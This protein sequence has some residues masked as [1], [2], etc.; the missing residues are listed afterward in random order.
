MSSGA[1]FTFV[2]PT[3][4][5]AEVGAAEA[6]GHIVNR[7]RG[8]ELMTLDEVFENYARAFKFPHYFG[9]NFA[10]LDECLTD[11]DWLLAPGYLTVITDGHRVLEAEPMERTALRRCLERVGSDWSGAFGLRATERGGTV[12]FRTILMV[13]GEPPHW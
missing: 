10:A 12:T 7:L 2:D 5:A 11:L 6:S 3:Q 8:T 13:N 1:W 9:H 4:A